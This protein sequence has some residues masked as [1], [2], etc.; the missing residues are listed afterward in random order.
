MTSHPRPG[1]VVST[2]SFYKVHAHEFLIPTPN[3]I[4]FYP[5]SRYQTFV[6]KLFYLKY[7]WAREEGRH[8]R[9]EKNAPGNV[10]VSLTHSPGLGS[11]TLLLKTGNHAE[12]LVACSLNRPRNASI[13]AEMS[14]EQIAEPISPFIEV[15]NTP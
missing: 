15:V 14:N 8:K 1:K 5:R 9:K 12:L 2:P 7:D 4:T 3:D 11:G 13:I 6:F 10:S